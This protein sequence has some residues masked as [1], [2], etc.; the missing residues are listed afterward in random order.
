M[1]NTNAP[2]LQAMPPSVPLHECQTLEEHVI[3]AA[4]LARPLVLHTPSPSPVSI[5]TSDVIPPPRQAIAPGSP[6]HNSS[7][8][9]SWALSMSAQQ[10]CAA[11][12]ALLL[13][14]TA[15]E[16]MCDSAAMVA[17]TDSLISWLLRMPN[18]CALA[19]LLSRSDLSLE[20]VFSPNHALW[21]SRS[22]STGARHSTVATEPSGA[23]EIQ[24]SE[25]GSPT[26]SGADEAFADHDDPGQLWLQVR[27]L[28][29][30]L[31]RTAPDNG[32]GRGKGKVEQPSDASSHHKVWVLYL[33]QL[34]KLALLAGE[35][36]WEDPPHA[37]CTHSRYGPQVLVK[38]F[39]VTE[40]WM[41]PEFINSLWHP[42]MSPVPPDLLKSCVI[43]MDGLK[44]FKKLHACIN[45]R[46]HCEHRLPGAWS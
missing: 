33:S 6:A 43:P 14:A 30:V 35:G 7:P 45:E 46:H 26:G 25:S 44:A 42:G 38:G 5:T 1:R 8:A 10:L 24:Q 15:A 19:V 17:L 31:N 37:V 29:A 13:A 18:Q 41:A 22:N 11:S 40:E 4:T 39:A 16:C 20:E 32:D 3:A 2:D 21:C 36:H 27:Y 12:R 34:L 9:D 23:F 28:S